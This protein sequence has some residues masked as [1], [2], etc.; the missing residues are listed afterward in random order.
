VAFSGIGGM[1]SL[2]SLHGQPVVIIIAKSP[3]TSAFRKQV[4]NIEDHYRELASRNTVFVVAFS[5]SGEGVPSNVPFVVASNG[6]SVAAAYGMNGDF[7]VGVVGPDGNLDLVSGEVQRGLRI[8]E[9]IQN[10]F[11]A[12]N[13]AR[14][15]QP[16]GPPPISER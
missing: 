9:V 15:E 4:K 16:K 6:T 14:K 3:R 13:S 8:R 7:M 5:E 2:R 11:N 10:S 12:Q 1:K